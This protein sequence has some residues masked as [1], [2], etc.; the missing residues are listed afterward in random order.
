[1]KPFILFYFIEKKKKSKISEMHSK[2]Q[3]CTDKITE[4]VN[5]I[6]ILQKY[7]VEFIRESCRD[8]YEQ[9]NEIT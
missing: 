8:S 2:E 6:Q 9:S 7:I 3:E 1:M 5:S 4:K